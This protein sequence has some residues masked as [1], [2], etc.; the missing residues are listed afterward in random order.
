MRTGRS[1][2]VA[3]VLLAM[4]AGLPGLL[5]AACPAC[6]ASK[7]IQTSDCQDERASKPHSASFGDIAWKPA[8]SCCGRMAAAEPGPATPAAVAPS[9]PLLSF[10]S[11]AAAPAASLWRDDAQPA[12]RPESPLLHEGIGLHVLHSVFLI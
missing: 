12:R 10:V 9:A 5:Q 6:E 7:A 8:G 2:I 1:R 4:L 3:L 11:L